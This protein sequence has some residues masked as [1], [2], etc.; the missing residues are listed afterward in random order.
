M[1]KEKQ[2]RRI[3]IFTNLKE[4]V[5]ARIAKVTREQDIAWCASARLCR[6]LTERT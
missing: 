2:V 3:S 1:K 6:L 5:Q 4:L